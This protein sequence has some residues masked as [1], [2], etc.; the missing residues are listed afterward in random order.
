MAP[1]RAGKILLGRAYN[2]LTYERFTFWATMMAMP[3]VGLLA[4]DADPALPHESPGR[5]W[6]SRRSLTMAS[7]VAWITIHPI[8]SSPFNVDQVISFLNRDDHAKFRYITL[9]FGSKFAEVSSE[10]QGRQRRR[11]LQLRPPAAGDDRLR[12]R[13][14]LQLEVLRSVGHGSAARRAEAR[15][16][17]RA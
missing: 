12:R 1:L 6:R 3:F 4:V 8:N 16:S 11:R 17:V 15:Q 13:P 5:A 10:R 2:V 9:G 7:A 14:A